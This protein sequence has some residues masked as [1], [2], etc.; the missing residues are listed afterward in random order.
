MKETQIIVNNQTEFLKYLKEKFPLIHMSNVFFRDFHYGVMSYLQD[1]GMK[2]KYNDGEKVAREAG[3][4]FEK[5][6]IFRKID[7]QSWLLN[8]PEFAL[9]RVEK[10]AS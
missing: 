10:K 5:N 2:L 1:H 9:P 6:G 8:Y 7:H 4:A 3:E